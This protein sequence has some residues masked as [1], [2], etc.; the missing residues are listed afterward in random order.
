[1]RVLKVA[2]LGE[3]RIGELLADFM[4]KGRN[5]TVGTLA[6]LGQVDVRIASKGADTAAAEGLIAPVEAEIRRRLGDL[7]FGADTDTLEGLVG[8]RLRALP[9]AVGSVE[10]GTGGVLGER[11]ATSLGRAFAGGVVLT[12]PEGAGRLGVDLAGVPLPEDRVRLLALAAARWAG[13]RV[14]LATYLEGVPGS[15]PAVTTA[16]LAAAVD[17]TTEAR[18][19][20]VGGDPQSVRIR[21]AT[22]ALDLLRRS[23]AG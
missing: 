20:R 14:G 1:M 21:A 9:S 3:S 15:D 7:I 2:G 4:E 13:T 16:A 8:A 5:P 23:L 10:V 17:D 22:L 19:H 18:E 12:A 11:L 6:H